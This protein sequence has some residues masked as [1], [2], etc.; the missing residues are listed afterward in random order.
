MNNESYTKTY[1][2][3]LRRFFDLKRP[4]KIVFDCSNG[5]TGPVLKKVAASCSMLQTLFINDNP[6]GNFPAHGPN[7]MLKGATKQLETAVKKHKADLGIIFDAD[8]DRVFIIDN[9]GRPLHPDIVAYLLAW[10]LKPKKIVINTPTGWLVRNLK[11]QGIKIF[12]SPVGYVFVSR[13]MKKTGSGFAAEHSAHYYF[14]NFFYRDAGI[15]AAILIIN[16]VSLLPYR[17]SDFV[18]LLPQYY[19]SWEINFVVKNK[20]RMLKII[21]NEYERGAKKNSHS[22]GLKMEFNNYWFNVRPSNTEPLLRL[23]IETTSKKLL[24]QKIKELK[25]IISS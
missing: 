23:N 20:E 19:R 7:P 14:D 2:D 5:T 1:V 15:L 13:L 18:D 4:L 16:A 25:R 6:D 11:S 12:E 22:D 3:F 8:G 9:Q 17:L 10:Y 24:N 21:E